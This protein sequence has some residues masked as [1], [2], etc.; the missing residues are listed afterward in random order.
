MKIST[1]LL[2]VLVLLITSS[3]E[4]I[5]CMENITIGQALQAIKTG[6]NETVLNF[7]EQV[8]NVEYVDPWEKR[9]LLGWAVS[10]DNL[11]LTRYLVEIAH[12]NVNAADKNR[13]TPLIL[14]AKSKNLEMLKYLTEQEE[15]EV[16]LEATDGLAWTALMWASKGNLL[17][18]EQLVRKG[19][20]INASDELGNT[21]YT[22]S[23]QFRKDAITKFL[24]E[25]LVKQNKEIAEILHFIPTPVLAII[26]EG[27]MNG[28]EQEAQKNKVSQD[29]PQKLTNVLALIYAILFFNAI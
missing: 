8:K 29:F 9:T 17:I 22:I 1:S 18:V 28:K 13:N 16:D 12:A 26:T 11:L 7:L 19:A 6:N 5:L 14:A 4:F 27:Y 10:R 20:N 23:R 2:Y 25:E 21:P 3:S 24:A 15:Q